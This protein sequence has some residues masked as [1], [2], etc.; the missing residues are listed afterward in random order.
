MANAA[1]LKIVFGHKSAADC[2]ISVKFCAGKQFSATGHR[3]SIEHI[4]C[5]PNVVWALARGAFQYTCY[6]IFYHPFSTE[7]AGH[8]RHRSEDQG[9][10]AKK[11]GRRDYQ[12]RER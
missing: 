6:Y 3:R 7:R 2:R 10:P 4:F 12:A 5:F 8:Y 1:V 9:L 11:I